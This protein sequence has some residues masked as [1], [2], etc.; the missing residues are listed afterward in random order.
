MSD[1]IFESA[2]VFL[3]QLAFL[4]AR[5]VNIHFIAEGDIKRTLISGGLIHVLWLIAIA[6]GAKGVLM[7][8]VEHDMRYIPVIIF[9]L[10]G[11]L[12][13]CYIGLIRSK[14]RKDARKAS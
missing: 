7:V 9:S 3:S 11:S 1:I 10:I 5:T 8:M 6:I 13:G 14:K 4:Y 2:V 12:L